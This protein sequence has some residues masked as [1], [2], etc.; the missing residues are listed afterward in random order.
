MWDKK[1]QVK[2]AFFGII[3]SK[4]SQVH[5]E[6]WRL[7]LDEINSQVMAEVN[8]WQQDPKKLPINEDFDRI[9]KNLSLYRKNKLV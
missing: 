5:N 3:L 8:Y 7:K 2:Q 4:L 1:I 9:W 6:V